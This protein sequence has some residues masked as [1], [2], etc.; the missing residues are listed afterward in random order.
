MHLE[1]GFQFGSARLEQQVVLLKL[2]KLLLLE[3]QDVQEHSDELTDCW[4][5]GR[6][7][8]R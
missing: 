5:C 1:A 3:C 4:R 2:G 8:V 7:V 6:P